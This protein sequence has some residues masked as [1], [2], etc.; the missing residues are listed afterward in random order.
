MTT[1]LAFSIENNNNVNSMSSN[2]LSL[3]FGK[4]TKIAVPQPMS[5]FSP[6]TVSSNVD[7]HMSGLMDDQFKAHF[8]LNN[9][10]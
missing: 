1:V 9:M 5:V 6:A 4:N 8:C 7:H 2:W 10:S 3:H